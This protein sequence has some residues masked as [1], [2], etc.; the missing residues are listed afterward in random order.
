VTNEFSTHHNNKALA[1]QINFQVLRTRAKLLFSCINP[2]GMTSEKKNDKQTKRKEGGK[3][4]QKEG[5]NWKNGKNR[6]Q[7]CMGKEG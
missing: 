7:K 3:I 5:R 2:V 1:T 4:G 6:S